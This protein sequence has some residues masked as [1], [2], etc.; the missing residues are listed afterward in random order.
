MSPR[1]SFSCLGSS[2]ARWSPDDLRCYLP[3]RGLCRGRRGEGVPVA[4]VEDLTMGLLI[5][6]DVCRKALPPAELRAA[7]RLCPECAAHALAL[8]TRPYRVWWSRADV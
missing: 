8:A 4:R 6:C 2:L 7:T 5:P 1:Q 3:G